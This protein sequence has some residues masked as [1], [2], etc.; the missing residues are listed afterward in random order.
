MSDNEYITCA[1]CDDSITV[2]CGE[3]V[4]ASSDHVLLMDESD[5]LPRL[6]F[7][8]DD[9]NFDVLE[10]SD[11]TTHCP[12]KGDAVYYSLKDGPAHHQNIAWSYLDPL[13]EATE[14]KGMIAFFEERLDVERG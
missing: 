8:A 11:K 13:E 5:Y 1:R 9:V 7:P 14:I 3:T 12:H 10:P 6:Y 4:L 2:K